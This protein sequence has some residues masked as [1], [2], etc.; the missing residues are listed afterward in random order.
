MLRLYR[1]DDTRLNKYKSLAEKLSHFHFVHHKLKWNGLG[2]SLSHHM[3]RSVTNKLSHGIAT[4][5]SSPISGV[6]KKC[7]F[8]T[9]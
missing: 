9:F 6:I 8:S 5:D 1:T 3:K 2:L 7:S 4:E